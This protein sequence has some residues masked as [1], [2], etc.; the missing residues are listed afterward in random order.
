MAKKQKVVTLAPQEDSDRWCWV[1]WQE[2]LG[3]I[4][5]H[6]H[7]QHTHSDKFYT[8]KESKEEVQITLSPAQ[9]LKL[10]ES[11]NLKVIAMLSPA[12]LLKLYESVNLK[13]I[14]K[15]KELLIGA[16]MMSPSS[17]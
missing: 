4:D 6:L 10:Y 1:D 8:G 9:L 11:M 15:F 13:V 2:G 5:L 16:K 7:V 14:A 17:K 12:Q 3:A